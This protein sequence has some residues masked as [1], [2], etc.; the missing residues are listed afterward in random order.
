[1]LKKR[2]RV[3]STVL[4]GACLFVAAVL[5]TSAFGAAPTSKGQTPAPAPA[6]SLNCNGSYNGMSVTDLTVLDGQDC[7]FLNGSVSGN[8][9]QRGGKLKLAQSNVAGNVQVNGG[10]TFTIGPGS[11][12]GGNLDI[13]NLP[14]ALGP[15]QCADHV[16]GTCSSTT[17]ELR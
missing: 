6:Q 9:Q 17:M 8:I 7:S 12:I 15:T 11:T 13:H 2:F 4:A 1:V 5:V 3:V 16:G 10:G 14:T